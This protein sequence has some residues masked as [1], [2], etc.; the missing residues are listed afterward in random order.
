VSEFYNFKIVCV[1]LD[2]YTSQ[3]PY[4]ADHL[5]NIHTQ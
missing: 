4:I 2:C 1:G 3:I 5:E